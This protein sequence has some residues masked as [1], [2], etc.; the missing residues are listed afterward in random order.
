MTTPNPACSING[1]APPPAVSVTAG[2]TVNGALISS[3]GVNYWS[4]SCTS[5]DETNTAAAIN[6]TLSIN[7]TSKT[8]TFTAPA[9]GSALIFTSIVGINGF[10]LDANSRI[11]STFTTTFKVNVLAANGNAV[12][13]FN[14][15]SEQDAS[16]GWTGI[17]N[18][19]SRTSGGGGGSAGG[20]YDTTVAAGVNNNVPTTGK[21]YTTLGGATGPFS[22]TGFTTTA[23][24][25]SGL[26]LTVANKTGQ[27]WTVKHRNTGSTAGNR[28]NC[29]TAN[30]KDLVVAPGRTVTFSYNTTSSPNEWDV[31]AVGWA[32][33]T[34]PTVDPRDYGAVG[35]G[36]TDDTAA[37][38]AALD[39]STVQ[40][41]TEI[42]LYATGTVFTPAFGGTPLTY[43]RTTKPLGLNDGFNKSPRFRGDSQTS[44]GIRY[45]DFVGPMVISGN[46]T[47]AAL[48][49][50]WSYDTAA[51]YGGTG[52]VALKAGS[53]NNNVGGADQARLNLGEY[54]MGHIGGL[55]SMCFQIAYKTNDAAPT[56]YLAAIAGSNGNS[57]VEK[58]EA[59]RLSRLNSGGGAQIQSLLSVALSGVT[60]TVTPGSAAVTFSGPVTLGAGVSVSF[61][62]PAG[63]QQ[64]WVNT[65]GQTGNLAT[66]TF[67]GA[68]SGVTTATLSGSTTYNAP[69]G[70]TSI[71][72][73]SSAAQVQ[74]V[75]TASTAPGTDI[76][77]GSYHHIANVFDGTKLS[78]VIDGTV[79]AQSATLG[80][81][82]IIVQAQYEEF[83]V[84]MGPFN[85][86]PGCSNHTWL[87][88]TDVAWGLVRLDKAVVYTVSGGVSSSVSPAPAVGTIQTG[89]PSQTQYLMDFVQDAAHIGHIYRDAF[90][91]WVI[92]RTW[93][94]PGG[95]GVAFTNTPVWLKLHDGTSYTNLTEMSDLYCLGW[96][97]AFAGYAAL[98]A[99]VSRLSII[100]AKG[101][102]FS[103]YAYA[104]EIGEG[105]NYGRAV[106]AYNG[107]NFDVGLLYGC[108]FMKVRMGSTTTASW[109][110]IVHAFAD[111]VIEGER[112][113]RN[114]SRPGGVLLACAAASSAHLKGFTWS[115]ESSPLAYAAIV[116]GAGCIVTAEGMDCGNTDPGSGPAIIIANAGEGT[117]FA[118][119]FYGSGGSRALFS[120]RTPPGGAPQNGGVPITLDITN[121]STGL[122]PYVDAAHPGPAIVA[123]RAE[124]CPPVN[125]ATDADLILTVNQALNPKLRI[126][127]VGAALTT[128]RNVVYPYHTAGGPCFEVFNATAQQLYLKCSTGNGVLCNA[129]DSV[130]FFD[131]GTNF[132]AFKGTGNVPLKAVSISVSSGIQA[133]GTDVT[134][135]GYGFNHPDD[136][137]VS[138]KFNTVEI[139]AT[140]DAS[141]AIHVGSYVVLSDTSI[142]V[143][144]GKG[145]PGSGDVIVKTQSGNTTTLTGAWTYTSW[146]Y[147][148]ITG[149]QLLAIP[150]SGAVAV[151]DGSSNADTAST[152]AGAPTYNATDAHFNSL[153]SVSYGGS[154]ANSFA[155][156]AA[157]QITGGLTIFA[158]MRLSSLAA[159][160]SAIVGKGSA[161]SNC[162]YDTYVDN[163]GK[164][165]IVRRSGGSL[166]FATTTNPV[167]S[168]NTSY[169]LSWR[170][171]GTGGGNLA[172]VNG[173][174]QVVTTTTTAVGAVTT[175]AV[176][177]GRSSD[178]VDILTGS[179]A[180]ILIYSQ[181]MNNTDHQTVARAL[182][183]EAGL[184]IT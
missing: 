77:T 132:Q 1:T 184:P 4:V 68:L 56:N 98:G 21:L 165:S 153:P 127:N 174:S 90:S 54:W 3:A 159:A 93:V 100:A 181:N 157:L 143:I 141:S 95:L 110:H 164:M 52:F 162:E 74:I 81:N 183:I 58:H 35:D 39:D 70:G 112:G 31:S 108:Q 63:A 37:I 107:Q 16:F 10:G 61:W 87:G 13:A 161:A 53:S 163:A 41:G 158:V 160:R 22:V 128:T 119:V 124:F 17:V 64:D 149:L 137:V 99:K 25:L 48:G 23:L 122:A 180:K 101:V 60:A 33:Q 171:P 104:S 154:D 94:S 7:L 166:D 14:E 111:V 130:R 109:W 46:N 105:M 118:G 72:D 114:G 26:P 135:S 83:V 47:S 9:V 116:A 150:N 103:A 155:N 92:G 170:S 66:Y 43:Y 15:K 62:L 40:A 177:M 113:Y 51:T 20:Q 80:M 24:S 69:S 12:L 5:T 91:D 131:D 115:D 169:V 147:N 85:Q 28:I 76:S 142:H 139:Y 50:V 102:I 134:I 173:A 55:G 78:L 96:G 75:L 30:G 156:I 65:G 49:G 45:Q 167:V 59:Y 29:G 182:G 179:V 133:G 6:A 67:T 138:V 152:A 19:V 42:H 88:G 57:T 121:P 38:Q 175:T 129:K 82:S 106:P 125:M 117:S 151:S 71:G 123:K 176:W 11:N 2:S 34:P 8:F 89:V 84:G 120:W 86:F 144:T 18:N 73:G 148:T 126:T 97:E 32:H 146:T 79:A 172:A 140:V 178:S 36:V 27:V 145:T 136:P 168:A 44:V